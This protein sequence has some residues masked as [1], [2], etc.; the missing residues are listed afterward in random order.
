MFA[1]VSLSR[2]D[3]QRLAISIAT[4]LCREDPPAVKGEMNKVAAAVANAIATNFAQ[5]A[6]IRREAEEALQKLGRQDPTIDP[7]KLFQGLCERIAKQK[8]FVL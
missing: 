8:G 7:A 3:I 5:E 1:C 6:A 4:D 2:D